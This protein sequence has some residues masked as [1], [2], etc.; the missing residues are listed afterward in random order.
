[1][2]QIV[3]I[4]SFLACIA[5]AGTLPAE[6]LFSDS[7]TYPDGNLVGA[8]GSPWG[9]H[10]GSGAAAVLSGQ[11]EVSRSREEDVNVSLPGAPIAGS[12]A[13]V[14]YASFNVR[15]TAL[16]SNLGSYFGHL[17]NTGARC[18]IWAAATNAATGQFRLGVG[19]STAATATSGQLAS[20][21]SLNTD[22]LIVVR[23]E[24]TTGLSTIWL[25]PTDEADP[26]VTAADSPGTSLPNISTFAFRQAGGIGIMLID[27][28]LIGTS[29][30]DVTGGNLPPTIS[31]IAPQSIPA[32]SN[33]GPLPFAVG[34]DQTPAAQLMPTGTSNN[35]TLVPDGNI[36]FGGSGGSRT[37]TVT[38][39]AGQQGQATITLTVSDGT[40][41]AQT[42][43]L[44]KVGAPGIAAIA[45]QLTPV[46]TV[47]GPLPFGVTDAE[48]GA[49]ALTMSATSSNPA[50]LP[51][52]NIFFGGSGAT[53]TLTATPAAGQTGITTITVTVS[54]GVQSAAA[55][56][57]L[58]VHPLLGLLASDEFN[59]ADDYLVDWIKWIGHSGPPD[60]LF[61]TNQRVPLSQA[62][63]GDA[64]LPLIAVGQAYPETGGHVFF[65]SFKANFSALP[66]GAGTY[67]A[68]FKDTTNTF[69]ARVIATT[70]GAT[71]G[72]LRLGIA[73]TS[74]TA[75]PESLHP[76]EL[77]LGTDYLVVV[78]L[79][80]ATGES[81][82]WVNPTAEAAGYVDSTDFHL[83]SAI[84]SFAFRQSGPG[85]GMGALTVDDLKV[86]TA[87]SDVA[88]GLPVPISYTVNNNTLRLSWPA[89][90]GY[91][92][93][94]A[95]ALPA[96]PANWSN[97]PF[98]NEGA[99]D[100][101]NLDIST[102]SGF[103][104]LERSN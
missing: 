94:R 18:R 63:S 81:R 85:P 87:F 100:V 7:F 60:E 30:A 44:L 89:G 93:R 20:D 42:S 83:P 24:L 98:V 3:S 90:R 99:N 41:T 91:L 9:T 45:N 75:A 2:K 4:L 12:S 58:T 74:S 27:N 55:A 51:S 86:G 88:A 28:L 77:E 32:N 97:V 29:F 15:F 22:Y 80:A 73:C 40:A 25:N 35:Q 43:F 71:A 57:A 14:L 62:L 38:P 36:V 70:T 19:N 69:R 33:T 39:A 95:T 23:Y 59:R 79:N 47:F 61:I 37:V 26:G 48:E 72:R 54:D 1:M 17:N 6:V 46:S 104:R 92:L 50:L 52:G 5:G 11:L 67:F 34:D 53:R 68:H 13:P 66:A 96:A 8:A 102:G 103:F 82:L 31:A 101:S 78:R 64:S 84:E 49:G 65:A 56:F 76:T 21:L 16:P 10:G